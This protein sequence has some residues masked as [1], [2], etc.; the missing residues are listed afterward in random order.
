MFITAH[1]AV[2]VTVASALGIDQPAAAFALGWVLHYFGDALPH[3]DESLGE[4]AKRGR[5][6]AFRMG[7]MFAVDLVGLAAALLWCRSQGVLTPAVWAAVVGSAVPDLLVGLELVLRK[8]VTGPLAWLH[9]AAHHSINFVYSP[10]IGVP[11]QILLAVTL[12]WLI[13]R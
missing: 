9:E 10:W 8:P 12:W 11:L 3:G 7:L 6:P 4:W 13:G 1:A 2:S 5:I